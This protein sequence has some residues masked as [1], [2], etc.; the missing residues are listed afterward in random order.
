MRIQAEV[1]VTAIKEIRDTKTTTVKK[2][3]WLKIREVIWDGGRSIE[4]R[5]LVQRLDSLVML[6]L[7]LSCPI[8][9]SKLTISLA[10]KAK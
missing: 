7:S 8:Y 4:G 1:A 2:S 9:N 5:K 10:A 3:R 6:V